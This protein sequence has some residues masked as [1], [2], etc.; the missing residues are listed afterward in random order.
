MQLY[1]LTRVCYLNA[2]SEF[3]KNIKNQYVDSSTSGQ[4]VK[5][6]KLFVKCPY[7]EKL[8]YFLSNTI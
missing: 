8:K 6:F 5:I 3:M 2:N 1:K 7:N 4:T